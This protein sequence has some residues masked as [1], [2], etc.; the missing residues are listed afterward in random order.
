[1]LVL[2]QIILDKEEF[3]PSLGFVYI[4][5]DHPRTPLSLQKNIQEILKARVKTM[6]LLTR[7]PK[8]KMVRMEKL[9]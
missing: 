7:S 4:D 3:F 2:L 1:M 5:A 9:D 6:C 8:I